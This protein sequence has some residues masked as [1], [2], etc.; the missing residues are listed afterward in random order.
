MHPLLQYIHD[1]IYSWDYDSPAGLTQ[2][3]A[4]L[5]RSVLDAGGQCDDLSDFAVL[6]D[7]LAGFPTKNTDDIYHALHSWNDATDSDQLNDPESSDAMLR[8]KVGCVWV[9]SRSLMLFFNPNEKLDTF[10]EWQEFAFKNVEKMPGM[11]LRS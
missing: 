3:V 4:R 6:Y 11:Y 7:S 1:E 9:L 5:L 8:F 10:V 2:S